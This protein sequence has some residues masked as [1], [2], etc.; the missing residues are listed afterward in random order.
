ME[1]DFRPPSDRREQQHHR[2]ERKKVSTCLV[3]GVGSFCVDLPQL[4]A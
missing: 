3:A 4:G 1:E 2:M